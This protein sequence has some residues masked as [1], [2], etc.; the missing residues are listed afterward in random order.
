MLNAKGNS[1][2]K[3]NSNEITTTK[4]PSSVV[5]GLH[6][7]L[8][9]FLTVKTGEKCFSSDILKREFTQSCILLVSLV[10]KMR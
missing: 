8:A 4:K 1:L 10:G 9:S 2:Q 7:A 3:E 5:Y 6:Y